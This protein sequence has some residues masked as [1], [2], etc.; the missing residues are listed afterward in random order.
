MW[1]ALRNIGAPLRTGSKSGPYSQRLLVG[2]PEK[3][4]QNILDCLDL[5]ATAPVSVTNYARAQDLC[6]YMD[7]KY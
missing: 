1:Y 7:N 5:A 2:F 3:N 6:T 4:L